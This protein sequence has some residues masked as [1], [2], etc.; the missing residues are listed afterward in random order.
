LNSWFL[1]KALCS[2][3]FCVETLGLWLTRRDARAIIRIIHM[4]I[5]DQRRGFTLIELLVVIAIIAIL[6]AMLLPALSQAKQQA[7]ATQCT[8]N[9]G[10]LVLAWKMYVDDFRGVFPPNQEGGNSGWIAAG[11]MNYQGSADDTNLQD[12]LGENA[13]HDSLMAPYVLKQPLIFKCPADMSCQFGLKGAPRI[14]TYSMTQSI[15]YAEN[16][17][18]DGQG[19][20]LPSV[21]NSGPWMC[22]FREADL[23]RPAPSMLWIFQEEDP[24]SINDAAWAFAMP[25]G[26]GGSDTAWIDSPS[27]LHGKSAGFGFVDGHCEMHGWYNLPAIPNITYQGEGGDP[28]DYPREVLNKNRDVWWVAARSSALANGEQD[29][30]PSN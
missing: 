10:Q 25:T 3:V 29:D 5:N 12:L 1:F 21:Y 27:K 19:Y 4:K 2:P 9:M 13:G 28:G 26:S 11:E 22:Y 30:F 8:S 6:A 17:Q 7:V 20:W 16:G 15:G 14:R 23:T 18:P 24:D